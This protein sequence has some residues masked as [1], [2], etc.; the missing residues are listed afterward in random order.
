MVKPWE[1]R[2]V[3][4]TV[5]AS[6]CSKM[7]SLLKKIGCMNYFQPCRSSQL[8]VALVMNKKKGGT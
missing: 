2:E 1:R 5:Q 7:I 3:P 4:F 6:K 8:D